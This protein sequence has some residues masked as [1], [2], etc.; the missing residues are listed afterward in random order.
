[1][2]TWWARP[3]SNQRPIGYEPTALPLSYG[4]AMTPVPYSIPNPGTVTQVD[5]ARDGPR[6]ASDKCQQDQVLPAI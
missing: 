2:S 5:E 3:D 6:G 1:M 4:P